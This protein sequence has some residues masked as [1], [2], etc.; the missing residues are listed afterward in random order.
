MGPNAWSRRHNDFK[1]ILTKKQGEYRSWAAK[2]GK[3]FAH[4]DVFDD[5][6]KEYSTISRHNA[7]V[8]IMHLYILPCNPL[9]SSRNIR[10]RVKCVST[11]KRAAD[12]QG[13]YEYD[14]LPLIAWVNK[15][16]TV[17]YIIKKY[18]K[19]SKNLITSCF[20]MKKQQNGIK[21]CIVK[22]IKWNEYKL[23]DKMNTRTDYLMFRFK[24]YFDTNIFIPQYKKTIHDLIDNEAL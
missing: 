4:M 12:P 22:R 2:A 20:I 3:H 10:L 15:T 7:S 23:V 18:L 21:K 1:F 19:E 9:D 17:G 6:S 16:D 14:G 8:Q 13:E 11:D 24:R 5:Y